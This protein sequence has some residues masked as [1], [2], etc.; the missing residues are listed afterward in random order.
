VVV[1]RHH[2]DLE[3]AVGKLPEGMLRLTPSRTAGVR[4]AAECRAFAKPAG[5]AT[6]V[7]RDVGA[8]VGFTDVREH[9]AELLDRPSTAVVAS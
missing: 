9:Y 8:D 6:W 7:P 3:A 4:F 2:L 1:D 5:S